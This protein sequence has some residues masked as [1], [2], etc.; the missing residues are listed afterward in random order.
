MAHL[1]S[2]PRPAPDHLAALD[3]MR[4]IAIGLVVWYHV[5]LISWLGADV[6]VLGKTYNFNVFPESGF[7]GVDLFFF[8]SGFCLFYPYAQTLFDGRPR[9]SVLT[10]A[11]RRILKIVP[12][13]Y[14]AI[15]LMIALG[16]A[17]FDSR[18]DEVKQVL[19][20]V[21]FVHGLWA[22]TWGGIQGVFWS[23]GVEVQFY[24]L[25]PVLCWVAMR[26]P[27]ALFPV[28][29]V[30][31]NLYRFAVV[32]HYNAGQELDSLPG[33]IDLFAGGMFT[34]WAFRAVSTRYPGLAR[35]R[36]LWTAVAFVAFAGLYVALRQSFEHRGE[37]GWNDAWKLYTRPEVALAFVP[38]TLGSLLAFPA[39]QRVLAN[40]FFVF[41]SFVSYN[42]YLWHQALAW[43]LRD[44]RMPPWAGSQPQSDPH[45]ALPYTLVTMTFA[46][47][48][49]WLLT[50]LVE[51]PFLRKRPF[52]SFF[53]GER[54]RPQKDAAA[55]ARAA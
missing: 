11:Y 25:F 3:G 8:I 37:A 1:T 40:P 33:T 21:F 30:A 4:G 6:T 31:A 15:V 43:M 19:A 5:W 22:D 26:W 32:H 28:L 2:S 17:H 46:I 27:A 14:L 55:G 44:A 9:Q 23:L 49:A 16:F 53:T 13:Y 50:I 34:A 51:Q 47:L 24:V 12:S 52:Q 29:V 54:P 41:L 10:F 18:S 42:L 36:V 38:A 48:V 35:N 7:A 39:W 20:H 45:W